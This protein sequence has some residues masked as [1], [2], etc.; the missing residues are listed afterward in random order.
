MTMIDS[1]K[2]RFWW[3]DRD[4]MKN[5]YVKVIFSIAEYF[6]T[7]LIFYATTVPIHEWFHLEVA[8]FFGGDGVIVKTVY[9]GAMR[10]TSMPDGLIGLT[11]TAFAGGIGVALIYSLIASLDWLDD[12]EQF[13]A[14][15][16]LITSQL[17]YGL[18][19]GIFLFSVSLQE[20]F[21]IAQ[22]AL[23]IG[24]VVGLIISF[25]YIANHLWGPFWGN[26]E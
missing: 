6:L 21:D 25:L 20:F 9:G 11:A 7:L 17:A 13:A 24:W 3:K 19:E 2:L 18:A 22:I 14:M 5:R 15:I 12:I 8:Q 1:E 10:F 16:P 23:A 4:F 26:K